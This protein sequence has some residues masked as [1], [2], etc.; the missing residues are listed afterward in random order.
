MGKEIIKEDMG[1]QYSAYFEQKIDPLYLIVYTPA[2]GT[3]QGFFK[4]PQFLRQ[5]NKFSQVLYLEKVSLKSEIRISC[6][7][8]VILKT[9]K[10]LD[11]LTGFSDLILGHDTTNL[12]EDRFGTESAYSLGMGDPCNLFRQSLCQLFRPPGLWRCTSGDDQRPGP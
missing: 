1:C 11:N 8:F 2:Q 5:R 6:F 9:R 12:K 3:S 10:R 4:K 7:G